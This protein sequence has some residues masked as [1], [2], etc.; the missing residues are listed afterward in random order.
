MFNV[1][2]EE[3]VNPIGDLNQSKTEVD[4]IQIYLI[5]I[6]TYLFLFSK[7]KFIAHDEKTTRREE[8]AKISDRKKKIE[9]YL[10][11]LDKKRIPN[12][13]DSTDSVEKFS[14]G[15]EKLKIGSKKPTNKHTSKKSNVNKRSFDK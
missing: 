8:L 15:R 10:E 6:K 7:R 11:I 14:K 9:K 13:D 1:E 4:E 2:T 3:Q 12:I 5:F